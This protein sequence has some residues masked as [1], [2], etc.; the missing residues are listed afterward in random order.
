MS[1]E[2]LAAMTNNDQ[3]LFENTPRMLYNAYSIN[4]PSGIK[5]MASVVVLAPSKTLYYSGVFN[6]GS[7]FSAN[8]RPIVVPTVNP[9]GGAGHGYTSNVIGIGMPSPDYRG[10][11]VLVAARAVTSQRLYVPF[12]AVGW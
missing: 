9:I 11:T 4:K 5:I 8:S 7:F 10:F 6:F 12:I 2:K 3:W 1:T